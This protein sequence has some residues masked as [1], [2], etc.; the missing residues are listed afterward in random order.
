MISL[1][2]TVLNEG[3]NIHHLM[4][5]LLAQTLPAD[6][7]IIVDGGSHDNTLEIL[8][9]YESKLPLKILVREGCNISQGRNAAIDAAKGDI[10]AITDAGVRLT[11]T[12]LEKITQPLREDESRTVSAGFF[13]ADPQNSFELAMGATVLPLAEE[14]DPA[15]FLPS[16]RSVAVRKSAALA[17]GGYPEWLDYCEDL[18]FDLRLKATQPPF[19]FVPDALVYFR[20]RGSLNSYFKQYYRYARGDGKADL[21]RKRHAIRYLTYFVAAPMIFLLGAWLHPLLYGLFLP[22]GAVYLYQPYRRLPKLMQNAPDKSLFAWLYVALLIP[23]IRVVGDVAK[24][25]GYP[26]GWIW[27]LQNHPPDWHIES[28]KA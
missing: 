6:E 28:I 5:G 17:V 12:W 21:W 15:S 22:A 10:L 4:N 20:P 7:I 27:R 24:I 16:S 14:I 18:I 26:V 23:V 19:S 1:I 13:Q 25:L 3:D 8:C 9:S 2:A 11:D